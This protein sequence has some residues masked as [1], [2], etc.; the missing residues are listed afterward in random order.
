MKS[1]IFKIVLILVII[2]TIFAYPFTARSNA[3][4]RRNREFCNR[5]PGHL[6]DL[7]DVLAKPEHFCGPILS[8]TLDELCKSNFLGPGKKEGNLFFFYFLYFIIIFHF[9]M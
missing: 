3:V 7:C 1:E 4:P 5:L 2:K 8:N 6:S 9:I